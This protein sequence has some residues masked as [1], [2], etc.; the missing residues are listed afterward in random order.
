MTD[1]VVFIPPTDIDVHEALRDGGRLEIGRLA[2]EW[3]A[4]GGRVRPLFIVPPD[5]PFLETICERALNLLNER[6]A[7]LAPAL[8]AEACQTQQ[9]QPLFDIIFMIGSPDGEHI[10]WIGRIWGVPQIEIVFDGRI[11][12]LADEICSVTLEAAADGILIAVNDFHAQ[13][14]WE[15]AGTETHSPP[16]EK[17]NHL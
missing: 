11:R 14:W 8:T 15:S 6:L 2:L 12:R 10:R 4:A 17:H 1:E 7:D 3:T 16:T 9:P 13:T 5:P